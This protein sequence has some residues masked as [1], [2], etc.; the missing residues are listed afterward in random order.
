[1]HHHRC[2]PLMKWKV[3]G[4]ELLQQP[5]P[6]F[7]QQLLLVSPLP[8]FGHGLCTRGLLL[9]PLPLLIS[10]LVQ[11]GICWIFLLIPWFSMSLGLHVPNVTGGDMVG[12]PT[13]SLWGV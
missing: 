6:S 9:K 7:G 2:L 5:C 1:M 4:Q 11:A 13:A 3:R 8:L 12:W 10:R